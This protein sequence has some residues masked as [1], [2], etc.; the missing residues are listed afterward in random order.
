VAGDIAEE[1]AVFIFRVEVKMEVVVS[2][3]VLVT[4]HISAMWRGWGDT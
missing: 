1:H 3:A 4:T 2:S